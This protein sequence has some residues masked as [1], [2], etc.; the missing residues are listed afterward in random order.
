[1]NV[2]TC[3]I[4]GLTFDH[5][6][7]ERERR[8]AVFNGVESALASPPDRDLPAVAIAAAYIYHM[9]VPAVRTE[10]QTKR[11]VRA[12]KTSST[13]RDAGGALPHTEW[14]H[15]MYIYHKHIYIFL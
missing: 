12:I 6:G 4:G 15:K 8:A 9:R 7:N 13:A 1:M 3:R 5:G 10:N 11:Y 2:R 14:D